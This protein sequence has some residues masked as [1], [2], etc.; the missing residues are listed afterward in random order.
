MSRLQLALNVPDIDVAVDFYTKLFETQ[1]RKRKPGYAN[2]AIEDPSLKLLLFERPGAD[3]RLN[4]VGVEVSSTN[5]VVAHRDR[6]K[7]TGISATEENGTCCYA[8]QD[9]IWVDAP[10]GAWEIYTVLSDSETFATSSAQAD[11]KGD[12]ACCSQVG[13]LAGA[14]C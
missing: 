4:H 14:C 12:P 8:E 13:E 5:E 3:T 10:D 7:A 6:L 2:F 9:K 1:P 11:D